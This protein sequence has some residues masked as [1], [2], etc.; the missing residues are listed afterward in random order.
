L[1]GNVHEQRWTEALKPLPA[2]HKIAKAKP[3]FR[4]IEENEQKLDERLD[5]ARKNLSKTA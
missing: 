3:L 1:Q 4:K 5:K 2:K